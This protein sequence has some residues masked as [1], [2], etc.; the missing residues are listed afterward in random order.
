MELLMKQVLTAISYKEML[1]YLFFFALNF[2]LGLSVYRF[3]FFQNRPENTRKAWTTS[4][5]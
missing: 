5:K 2:P 4:I 3:L 1:F